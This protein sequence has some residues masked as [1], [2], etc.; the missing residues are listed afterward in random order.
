VQTSSNLIRRGGLAAMLGG[1]LGILIP[2]FFSVGWFATKGGAESLEHPLV[3]VWSEPFARIFSPLLTFAPPDVAYLTYGKIFLFEIL[4]FLFGLLA[5]HARQ[6]PRAGGLEKWGFRLALVG[7]VL[8]IVGGLGFYVITA[9]LGQHNSIG[10]GLVAVAWIVLGHA[11]WSDAGET[12][13]RRTHVW[14]NTG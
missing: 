11:L 9:L 10:W 6:A 2:P 7:S 4:G 12:V 13:K 1:I 3:A 14:R 8:L 5:L